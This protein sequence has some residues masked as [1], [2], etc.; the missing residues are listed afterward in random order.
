MSFKSKITTLFKTIY[1]VKNWPVL[2]NQL[3]HTGRC[4]TCSII[5]RGGL[6]VVFRR[7]TADWEVVKEVM[8]YG[9][10][11]LCFQHLKRQKDRLPILDLGA[12]IGLFSLQAA[13]YLPGLEIHAYEPAPRNVDVISMNLRANPQ[14]SSNIHVHSEAVGGSTRQA[15]FFYDE[16][17]PQGS[18]LYFSQQNNCVPVI[19]R[20]FA[21]IV[22]LVKGPVGLV[23][24]D[25][26]GAEY[27]IFQKT[28]RRIRECIRAISIEIHDDP[29]GKSKKDDILNRIESLSYKGK[30]E[31][32]GDRF[33]FFYR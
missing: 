15:S 33:Y 25:V 8:L 32:S 20:S 31:L 18:G 4:K 19:V 14:I 27:E 28:P 17:V 30:K 13:S 1:H 26:E 2:I 16:K 12:N 11:A 23:K 10:Y 24:I 22:E 5:F 29:E 21:E 6:K 9:V 7:G 3:P